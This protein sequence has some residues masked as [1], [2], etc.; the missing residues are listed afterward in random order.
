MNDIFEKIPETAKVTT[1][2]GPAVMTLMGMPLDQWILVLSAIVSLLV[3]IEKL[4]KV[5]TAIQNIVQW[6]KGKRDNPGS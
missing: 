5:I 3:I 4:P 6:V 2:V 1:A